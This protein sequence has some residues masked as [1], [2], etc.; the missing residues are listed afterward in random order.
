MQPGDLLGSGTISGS[1]DESMGSMLELS[2][3]GTREVAL[4]DSGLT[5]KFLQD[6]DTVAITGFC[7][8]HGYRIGFGSCEGKILPAHPCNT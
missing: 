3:Q 8:G 1:T 2:W 5:R 4:G 7:Q 6:G